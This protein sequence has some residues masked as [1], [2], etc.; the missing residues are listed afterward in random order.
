MADYPWTRYCPRCGVQLWLNGNCGVCEAP[1]QYDDVPAAAAP[2]RLL[3]KPRG[4]PPMTAAPSSGD[5]DGR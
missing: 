5:D 4:E 2:G 1:A 3:K